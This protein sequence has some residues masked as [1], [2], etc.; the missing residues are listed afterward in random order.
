MAIIR[1]LVVL[2]LAVVSLQ[3]HP[4]ESVSKAANALKAGDYE[5]ARR[6]AR[7]LAE[8]GNS[9]AMLLMGIMSFSGLG[10]ERDQ[11]KAFDYYSRAAED[12]QEAAMHNL[13]TMY[14]RGEGVA[15]D[16]AKAREWNRQAAES[17]LLVAQHDYATMLEAGVGGPKDLAG[18]GRFYDM[19]ARGG[20]P[21]A[22]YKMARMLKSNQ[23]RN[24]G[25][26]IQYLCMAAKAGHSRARSELGS[27]V[28]QCR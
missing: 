13:A 25:E 24:P 8:Q 22:A 3:V 23:N 1:V 17:G 28:Q 14:Y 7:P 16:F 27:S 11:R 4:N 21:N 5:E 19:A 10:V 12:G 26:Q 18:A 2:V 15:I 6:I 20:Y 9:D